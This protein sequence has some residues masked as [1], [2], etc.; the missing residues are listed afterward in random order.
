[1]TNRTS[2]LWTALLALGSICAASSAQLTP[3]RLYVGVDRVIPASAAVPGGLEGDVSVSLLEAGTGKELARAAAAEGALDLAGLFPSL[4]KSGEPKKVVYAQLNVGDQPIGPAVVIQP[5]LTPAT[6]SPPTSRTG[7]PKF[8]QAPVVFSGFRT[9]VDKYVRWETSDG[10]IIFRL[11]PDIAP[12]TAFNYR[13]LV[14]GGFYT[15]IIFHRVVAANSFVIQVGD[16]TGQGSGG[17]GYV[18]DLEQSSL[19]HD[20]G[21]LS[22]ARTGDPNSNGSQVFVCLSRAGTSFLDGRYTG[23]GEAVAGAN[24]INAIAATPVGDGDRPTNPPKILSAQLIDADPY[25]TGPEA[26]STQ[27]HEEL[28]VR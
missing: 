1:M 10:E 9:Y 21:V 8:D 5:L 17:P 14:E 12:N 6:A 3:D 7:A 11:R 20:F 15:D 26:L 25:G 2:T 27:A 23:F 16:P 13:H 4:W 18:I 22:M 24:A 28:Q 19:P